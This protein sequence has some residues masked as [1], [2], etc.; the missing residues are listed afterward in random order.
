MIVAEI[1]TK[2]KFDGFGNVP[3]LPS[4]ITT[5]G[6]AT[7]T[8]QPANGQQVVVEVKV[9]KQADLSGLIVLWS[10]KEPVNATI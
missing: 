6:D 5:F 8:P 3:D 1:L 7:R 4:H 9:N 2:W 10:K